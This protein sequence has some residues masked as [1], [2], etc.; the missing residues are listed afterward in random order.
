MDDAILVPG[1]H[2]S[3]F[4]ADDLTTAIRIESSQCDRWVV[5]SD[6]E[7]SLLRRC[8]MA[9]AR[10][11]VVAPGYRVG[12]C[13]RGV[14]IHANHLKRFFGIV[15]DDAPVHL[16]A[17]VPPALWTT[18]CNT[19][20]AHELLTGHITGAKLDD[21][22]DKLG[23]LLLAIPSI[24]TR[25][26]DKLLRSSFQRLDVDRTGSLSRAEMG[27]MISR[28]MPELIGEQ[29]T[30]LMDEADKDGSGM[31]KYEE[32]L[33]WL[34]SDVQANSESVENKYD[35]IKATFRLWDDNGDGL[36]SKREFGKVF[37]EVDPK[38]TQENMKALWLHVDEDE[39]GKIDYE[40]FIDFLFGEG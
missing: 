12:T 23:A 7:L 22:Q 32:W 38:M 11:I 18:R 16:K 10:S 1:T 30:Q 5:P 25:S 27:Q 17:A 2:K 40:E 6:D 35:S 37:R 13:K 26:V 8:V 34:K 39:D 33:A 4:T 20:V 15:R 14:F 21:V 29:I 28:I 24:A 3:Y 31:I 9:D 36:V 19:G